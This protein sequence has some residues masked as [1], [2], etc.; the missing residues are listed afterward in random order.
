MKAISVWLPLFMGLGT[1]ALDPV[2][3]MCARWDHQ[4]VVK[5]GTLYIDG[6]IETFGSKKPYTLG[7]N[8]WI[9]QVDMSSSWDWKTNISETTRDKVENDET[10]SLPPNSMLRGAMYSGPAHSDVV[11]TFGGSKF[12]LNTSFTDTYPEA[13]SY[14][15]WSLNITSGAW[16]QFDVKEASP[17]R[18]SRGAYAEAKDQALGFYFN[19]QLDKGS[20]TDTVGMGKT[21]IGLTGMVVFNFTDP[22]Q[23]KASN[24]STASIDDKTAAVG[25]S[26][27]YVPGVGDKG[28][29]VAAGGAAIPID[30]PAEQNGTMISFDTVSILDLSTL[31]VPNSNPTWLRQ[32][33][34]GQLPEPRADFCTVAV[35][36]PDNSSYNI[37]LYGGRDPTIP[38]LYDDMYVLS[39]P[40]FT[41]VKI[42][43]GE[44]PRFAHTCHLVSNRILLT[45]G[46]TANANATA[47][48]CDW[49][50]KGVGIMDLSTK[51]WGSVFNA[52][53]APY[54]VGTDIVA[55]VGGSGAG[56]ATVKAPINGGWGSDALK[57]VFFPPPKKAATAPS[58]AK[59]GTSSDSGAAGKTE[60]KKSSV[61]AIAGG[62]I[63]GLCVVAAFLILILFLLHRRKKA[64]KAAHRAHESGEESDAP[65]AGYM[66]GRAEADAA[67]TRYELGGGAEKAAELPHTPTRQL[68]ELPAQVGY[69]YGHHSNEKVELPA[70]L[71]RSVTVREA[72]VERGV[73]ARSKEGSVVSMSVDGERRGSE[74]S[75]GQE[76]RG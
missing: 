40:S 35:A 60:E 3:N 75:Y 28:I 6:G 13:S 76:R 29:L 22:A 46:G 67:S 37:Y 63:G 39:L 73:Q 32:K 17:L 65:L 38:K 44:S 8:Q 36:A 14:T 15:L 54:T 2:T 62:V 19:G 26:L 72:V 61:G 52:N 64:A 71:A 27:T 7:S 59:N 51:T 48:Q 43:S 4:S 49:E 16:R 45:V 34:G 68:V 33:T 18:P 56:A 47:F 24:V 57:A 20:S 9:I 42:Y 1:W 21:T 53:A 70:E 69:G 58:G 10:G 31:Y 41:W 12:A 30:S 11:Y 5:D 66:G 50:N 23:P 74:G 25:G 55:K